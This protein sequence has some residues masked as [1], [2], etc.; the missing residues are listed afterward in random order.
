MKITKSARGIYERGIT[1]EDI[2]GQI[3]TYLEMNGARVNRIVERIPY[4]R[5][6]S[7]PGIPDLIGWG[8]WNRLFV[9]GKEI[10]GFGNFFPTVFFIEVKRPGGKHRPA[11]EAWI[12]RAREDGILAFFAESLD[13][14]K[15]EFEM[16]GITLR[17]SW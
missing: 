4:G 3:R 15:R 14:V 12:A 11:Q 9:D 6:T 16:V 8:N 10:V 17:G 7:E 13:D 1:E 2:V 5:R